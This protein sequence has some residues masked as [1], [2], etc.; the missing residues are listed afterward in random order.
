MTERFWVKID[1]SGGPDT[2]WP[3]TASRWPNGYGRFSVGGRI[4]YA[5]RVAYELDRS[6][7]LPAERPFVLHHCDNPACC[8]ARHLFSG[9]HTDNMADMLAKGRGRWGRRTPKAEEVR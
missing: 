1:R 6:H 3:W 2:C 5:H 9:T 4:E 7:P 8:N